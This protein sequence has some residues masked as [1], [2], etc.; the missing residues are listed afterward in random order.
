MGRAGAHSGIAAAGTLADVGVRAVLAGSTA[1]AVELAAAGRR[2]AARG[3]SHRIAAVTA[4]AVAAGAT[5]VVRAGLA[6]A[7]I[8]TL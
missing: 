6:T 8:E 2:K 1:A 5:V 7:D 4:G 3:T